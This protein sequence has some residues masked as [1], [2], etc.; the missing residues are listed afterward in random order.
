[1]RRRLSEKKEGKYVYA[2]I[3]WNDH[4]PQCEKCRSVDLDKSA[5]FINACGEGAPLLAE[6]CVKHQ[7]PLQAEK[8]RQVREWAKKAG[9]FKDA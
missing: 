6:E 3:Y 7:R 5:T 9:V 8:D 2:N 1:M 4:A